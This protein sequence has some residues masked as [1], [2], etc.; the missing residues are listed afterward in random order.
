[1]LHDWH[2]LLLDLRL[3]PQGQLIGSIAY[4]IGV[5]IYAIAILTGTYYAQIKENQN[6]KLRN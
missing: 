1:M 3:L 5:I 2:F 4:T 6:R